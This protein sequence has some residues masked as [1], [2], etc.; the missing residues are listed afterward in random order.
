MLATEFEFEVLVHLLRFRDAVKIKFVD[1]IDDV[2]SNVS[3]VVPVTSE[4]DLLGVNI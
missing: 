4:S 2:N 1:L 3:L